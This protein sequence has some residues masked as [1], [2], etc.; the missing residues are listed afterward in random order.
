MR[1]LAGDPKV[2]SSDRGWLQNQMR[3]VERG[4]QSHIRNPIGK[5][6]AHERGREAAKGYPYQYAHLQDKDLHALQHRHD[7]YGRKNKERPVEEKSLTPT[8][9]RPSYVP[10]SRR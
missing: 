9:K 7:D 3:H 4:D 6:L 10:R 2:A 1:E 5:E 8:D